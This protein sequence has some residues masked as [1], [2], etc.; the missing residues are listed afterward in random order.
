L[1]GTDLAD[2]VSTGAAAKKCELQIECVDH[3]IEDYEGLVWWSTRHLRQLHRRLTVASVQYNEFARTYESSG[4]SKHRVTDLHVSRFQWCVCDGRFLEA[5]LWDVDM[6]L[7]SFK[8]GQDSDLVV[9]WLCKHRT[10]VLKRLMS[11]DQ[12]QE[13]VILDEIRN[14]E[15]KQRQTKRQAIHTHQIRSLRL[16]IDSRT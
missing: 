3:L 4:M 7:K 12:L 5:I 9:A 2:G 8:E 16:C 14:F 1:T 11:M 10:T 15:A 13:N 6:R